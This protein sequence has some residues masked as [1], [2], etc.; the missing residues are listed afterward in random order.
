[1]DRP[2]NLQ[3]GQEWSYLTRPHEHRSTLIIGRIDESSI[4]SVFHI[5]VR[6]LRLADSRGLGEGTKIDHVPISEQAL[7]DSLVA[8][9]GFV[10]ITGEFE[11]GYLEWFA[12]TNGRG[13][14]F[15]ISVAE[16]VAVAE[17]VVNG[18]A[19]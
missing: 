8:F 7:R 3:V 1:M 12:S 17:S 14:P 19:A 13:Q 9:Q 6:G 4:G 10:E 16:V 15:P 2:L 5:S 11:D 18:S